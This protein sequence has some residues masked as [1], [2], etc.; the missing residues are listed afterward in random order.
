MRF[1]LSLAQGW[2]YARQTRLMQ[3]VKPSSN[4]FCLIL[5]YVA[6]CVNMLQ[7]ITWVKLIAFYEMNSSMM[8]NNRHI[9]RYGCPARAF[10][11]RLDFTYWQMCGLV[12][13]LTRQVN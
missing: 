8:S 3:L 6:K 12:A 4:T 5:P 13:D 9:P 2:M 10:P 7:E 11:A 1:P